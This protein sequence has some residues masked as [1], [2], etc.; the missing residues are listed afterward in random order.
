MM[1]N[2]LAK[3]I[4]AATVLAM[5]VSLAPQSASAQTVSSTPQ[6]APAQQQPV[7]VLEELPPGRVS[8]PVNGF[9]EDT[10]EFNIN[11]SAPNSSAPNNAKIFYGAIQNPVYI[12]EPSPGIDNSTE[13][14]K[15]YKFNPGDLK[16]SP[17]EISDELR[18]VL[19][20]SR[21]DQGPSSFENKYGNT[22]VKYE[23]RLEDNSNPKNFVNFAFYAPAT[24]P[25]TNL[26]SLSVFNA[27]N[28]T[29]FLNSQ[30]QVRFPKYLSPLNGP[31]LD[32]QPNTT[33]LSLTPIPDNVTKVPEPAAT[34]S[35]LGF[36]IVSTALLRKRNKRLETSLSNGQR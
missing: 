16:V 35:L 3:V 25:F 20:Q 36:G 11:T 4:S 18:D 28:L 2:R 21:D 15:E 19:N 5:A 34:A 14:R 13:T 29:P 33:L 6:P 17:V 26:N 1:I 24:E 7:S 32:P 27:S 22:V 23:S 8:S 12:D 31:L 10:L 9:P 30:G